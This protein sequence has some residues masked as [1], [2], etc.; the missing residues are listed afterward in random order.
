MGLTKTGMWIV[1]TFVIGYLYWDKTHSQGAYLS[2]CHWA[3]VQIMINKV[4]C[5]ECK[6][7]CKLVHGWNSGLGFDI[8]I[9]NE[10]LETNKDE[11]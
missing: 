8:E 4:T 5:L 1:F 11:E 2:D 10:V 9:V 3:N 6:Q 7:P